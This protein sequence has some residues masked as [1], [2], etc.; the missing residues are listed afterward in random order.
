MKRKIIPAA[1][2]IALLVGLFAAVPLVNDLSAGQVERSLVEIIPP[3]NTQI[4]ESLSKAGKL[5]GN[6]NG[7][8]Y[9][10]AILIK[11]E[12]TQE[13]LAAYYS[14]IHA[15]IVVKEQ[16]TQEIAFIE[17]EQLSFATQITDTENYY[18]VYRFGDGIALFEQ[19][20]LRGH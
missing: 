14:Q 6:G 20:D 10:G 7:M 9:F 18:I 4:V 2:V 8:Q 3:E 19:L 12:L 16:K 5:V 13:E 1:I 15:D 17:H 11:S